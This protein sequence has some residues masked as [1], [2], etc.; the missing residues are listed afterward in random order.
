MAARIVSG[1]AILLVLGLATLW[2]FSDRLT[3]ESIRRAQETAA[4]LERH[5]DVAHRQIRIDDVDLHHVT[6]GNPH[7]PILYLIHGTPGDWSIFAN[8]FDDRSLTEHVRLIAVDRP[9]WGATGREDLEPVS[10]AVQGRVIAKAVDRLRQEHP[11]QSLIVA[12]HSLGGS[13]VAYL[14]IEYPE[15]IDGAVVIAGDLS[16]P[17]AKI[18]WYNRCAKWPLVRN[19][20]G[21]ALRA[22]NREVF[23]LPGE[24]EW[25]VPRW[26]SIDR[27]IL[28]IQGT[29]DGLVDPG[30]AEYAE[31]VIADESLEVLRVEGAGHMVH[32]THPEVVIPAL[33]RFI[34]PVSNP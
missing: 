19:L 18:R 16:A 31:T 20:I 25:M 12:G 23:A 8:L 27:P 28:V 4:R 33:L 14:A 10:F 22:S 11:E 7:G 3:P 5:G 34:S 17:L 21:E 29:E 30:N 24:L 13:L 9:G 2:V 15:L 26:S 32:I 6:A 1:L